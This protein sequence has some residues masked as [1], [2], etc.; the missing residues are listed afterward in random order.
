MAIRRG[1]DLDMAIA[2]AVLAEQTAEI[3]VHQL[4]V[5]DRAG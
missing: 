4:G 5:A 2:T 1:G 3:D